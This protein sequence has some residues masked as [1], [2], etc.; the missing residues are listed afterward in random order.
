MQHFML[1]PY[2]TIK[3]PKMKLLALAFIILSGMSYAQNQ[4]YIWYFGDGN[5][6]D[7]N[8]NFNTPVLTGQGQEIATPTTTYCQEGSSTV[9]DA[10]GNLLFYNNSEFVFD[11]NYNQ[12]PNGAGLIGSANTSAQTLAVPK[13]GSPDIYYIFHMDWGNANPNNGLYYTEVDMSLNGGLGDVTANKNIQLGSGPCSEQLKAITH[14]N[15]QDI[16]VIAHSLTGNTFMAYLVSAAGVAPAVNTAIGAPHPDAFSGM[17]YI[18]CTKDGSKIAITGNMGGIP[19]VEVFSFDNLNGTLCNPQ[20]LPTPDFVGGYG[21]EFSA[22]GTKLYTTGFQLHQY[23]FATAS[24]YTFPPAEIGGALMRGPN[25]KIYLV[26][27]C[28][29]YD[30]Q[31]ATMFYAR[32]IHVIENPN[33][34]GA[35]A[36]LQ[37]NAYTTPREAGLGLPTCYYP[38]QTTNTCDPMSA[39]FTA[40]NTTI[41]EGDCITFTN[42]STGAAITSY[43]WSFP[44][45]A[46]ANFSGST[47]P[48]VCYNTQ[49]TYT[50]T[51]TL[52]DCA[53]LTSTFD[54]TITVND[55]SGPQV[56]F[57][58]SQTQIC[59]NDC[60]DFTDLSV[61]TNI[62]A[63]DWSF[64]GANTTASNA[65]NPTGICYAN[66]GTYDVTL[67]VTDDLGTNTL[68]LTNYV[69]V[70]AC[71]PPNANF[72]LPD[73]I[74]SGTCMDFTDL[75]TNS[76]TQWAWTFNGATPTNS[77][78]QHPQNVCFNTP[79]TYT[80]SLTA[81][82][83][84]GTDTYDRQVVVLETPNAGNDV[85]AEWC[86]TELDQ[87]LSTML[88]P[89]VDLTGDW[90]N[91]QNVQGFQNGIFS[92]QQAGAGTH[93]IQ[94]ALHNFMCSDT[95]TFTIV[96]EGIGSAG[97][98]GSITVCDY[99]TPI[100]LFNVLQGNPTPGG[101]WSPWPVSG[102]SI[103]D[104]GVDASGEYTYT[105]TPIVCVLD[106]SKA[107]VTINY[108]S[109]VE[110]VPVDI[111]CDQ[112][113]PVTLESN[114]PG[115]NWSGTGITDTQTGTFD[116]ALS[117]NG[118][119][120]VTYQVDID[121]CSADA[122]VDIN[123]GTVPEVDLGDDL[124]H[125]MNEPLPFQVEGGVNENI[126]WSNGST[127]NQT[128]YHFENN[129]PGETVIVGVD[130]TNQCGTGSDQ[131]NV[132]LMDCELYV[133]V[134][135]S[136]TPDGNEHNQ[137]FVPVITGSNISDYSLVI[138]NRW[139]ELVFET[140]ELNQGWDGSY[141][142]NIVSD[143]IYTWRLRV[144]NDATSQADVRE[145][146]GHI[147]LIR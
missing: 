9:C 26:A 81:T 141:M 59:A 16:W 66:P 46:P 73:T 42:A 123:V 104:P 7:F 113:N 50:A 103:L 95:M 121:H 5:F 4:N 115:G 96:I 127:D 72:T 11:Q 85:N 18:T 10:A 1:Y 58:A 51:L 128:I 2:L 31:A 37:Q 38:T 8:A 138:F 83:P 82:N 100:D 63:W 67:T 28:D 92:P 77:N 23:D 89:G 15:G 79:G 27:G 125:C 14:C 36:N 87:D 39:S 147:T 55:C 137:V 136:F 101:T 84:Y 21:V 56:N 102:T 68:T 131:V 29:Y 133:Y 19:S 61:G 109:Q 111:L 45:G 6:L 142:G 116:P 34:A 43:D 22:D 12:M 41:C 35:A 135:N 20:N 140:S 62:S 69:T 76:P 52:T 91:P 144:S 47:P 48:Q 145:Y 119:H 130:V 64:P 132:Q 54:L 70:D 120:Q 32:N 107:T 114:V 65:Q 3:D 134:P 122:V 75:S 60:I 74:C 86:E 94:Y 25:D 139:G 99:D 118:T 78:V 117:G 126:E 71:I 105:V 88:D 108:V 80:L 53:G 57:Q 49:G 30:Q 129:V 24:W 112:G 97:L 106:S 44:G 98:D 143:G 17:S 33:N 146:S 93:T 124:I 40:T 110:I 13:P 90:L